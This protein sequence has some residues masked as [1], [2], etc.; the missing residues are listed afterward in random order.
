M[1]ARESA[2]ILTFITAVFFFLCLKTYVRSPG[3]VSEGIDREL[4]EVIRQRN[5]LSQ[6]LNLRQQRYRTAGMPGIYLFIY[7]FIYLPLG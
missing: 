7:L 2:A 1:Y 3:S 4:M 6:L 5:N